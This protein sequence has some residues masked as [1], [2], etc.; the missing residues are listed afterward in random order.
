MFAQAVQLLE[1]ALT[2]R[3]PRRSVVF[4]FAMSGLFLSMNDTTQWRGTP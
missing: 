3:R 4:A 2:A 1:P